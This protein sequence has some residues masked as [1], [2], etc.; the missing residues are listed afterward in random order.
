VYGEYEAVHKKPYPFSLV[1]TSST[2]SYYQMSCAALNKCLTA[3][4]RA[5][6][7]RIT[8]DTLIRHQVVKRE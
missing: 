4:E 1:I 7:M 5:Q 8:A 6:M 2:A 3:A